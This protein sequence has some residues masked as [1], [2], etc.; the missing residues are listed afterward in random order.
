MRYL[1]SVF[2]PPLLSPSFTPFLHLIFSLF[3]SSFLNSLTPP[4]SH[5]V[6]SIKM[7]LILLPFQIKAVCLLPFYFV[8]RKLEVQLPR[9]LLERSYSLRNVLQTLSIT[10]V[11]QDDADIINMG[12]DKGPKL[13]Q[14]SCC[15]TVM[16]EQS[17]AK[18]ANIVSLELMKMCQ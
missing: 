8:N 13:T 10:Q 12:G 5:L 16:S 11:F 1:L 9:F 3:S 14:V 4:S 18:E 6:F 17:R 2:F 7:C 15:F